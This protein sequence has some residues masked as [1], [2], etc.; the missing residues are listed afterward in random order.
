YEVLLT[1]LFSIVQWHH[2]AYMAISIALL[3]YGASGSF[4]A[5]FQD[6]LRPRF[7]AVFALSATL[8]GL[9]AV[10][11]FCVAQRLPFNALAVIWDPRLLFFLVPYYLLFAIPFF[12]AAPCIGLALAAFPSHIAR[13]YRYDMVGAGLGALGIVAVLFWLFPS[14]ALRVVGSLGLVAAALA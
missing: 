6:R 12:C 13:V 11:G 7:T 9:S 5:L 14:Q 2:F 1:R 3:G 8:F 4:L 10:A